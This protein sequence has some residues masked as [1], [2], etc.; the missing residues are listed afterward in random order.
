[1]IIYKLYKE[2]LSISAH[3]QRVDDKKI[4]FYSYDQQ[5]AK[6]TVQIKSPG[7]GKTLEAVQDV[8]IALERG[9]KK[10]VHN[11]TVE[12][13]D[14]NLVSFV[15]PDNIISQSGSFL[16]G[17]YLDYGNNKSLDVGYF[18]INL[19]QSLIDK[20]LPAMEQF[21]VQSFEELKDDI[22]QRSSDLKAIIDGIDTDVADKL[23]TLDDLAEDYAQKAA[24]LEATYAP[25]L[26]EVTAELAQT[27]QQKVG[28]GVKASLEDLDANVLGAIE[29]GEGTSFNLLS[30]PQDN[31]VTTQK[32]ED[33]LRNDL[34]KPIQNKILNGNFLNGLTNW[35]APSGLNANVTGGVVTLTKTDTGTE[36]NFSQ[37][38]NLKQGNL[39]YLKADVRSN[40]PSMQINVGG[41]GPVSHT[42]SGNFEKLS[43]VFT[44]SINGN[45]TARVRFFSFAPADTV[46]DVTKY[47]L[48]DLTTAFGAGN[49]PDK[50]FMDDFID[51]YYAGYFEDSGNVA[52][53][54]F[55]F[56]EVSTSKKEIETIKTEQNDL[57]TRVQTVEEEND[58]AVSTTI[59]YTNKILTEEEALST[60]ITRHV[61]SKP[62][63]QYLYIGGDE[64]V[65]VTGGDALL[66][67]NLAK[68][69]DVGLKVTLTGNT[70]A[71]I[72]KDIAGDITHFQSLCA[73]IYIEDI[74]KV[75]PVFL[76]IM[77]ENLVEMAY[78]TT[79]AERDGNF[80]K[81][82]WNLMRFRTTDGSSFTTDYGSVR[83]LRITAAGNES[84]TNTTFI[85][86]GS[87]WVEKNEKAKFMFIHDGG[88]AHF[89]DENERGY[90]DLKNRG[91]PVINA[92][93]P[94]R[95]EDN[96][97]QPKFMSRTRLY[98]TSLENN[99]EISIHSYAAEDAIATMTPDELK[100][101]SFKAIDLLKSWGYNPLWRAAWYRNNAP[102]A[103]GSKGLFYAFAMSGAYSRV[104]KIEAFPF[105]NMYNVRRLQ[106]HS[107]TNELT[108]TRF[109]ELQWTRGVFVG[110]THEVKDNET[111][112]ISVADWD[113]LLSKLDAAMAEGWL[114]CVTF[115][116]LMQPYIGDG[117][118]STYSKLPYVYR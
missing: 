89:F 104:E 95:I 6:I 55:L 26:T 87:V 16:C 112:D 13:Y 75:G 54:I 23:Q 66:D 102:S 14:E 83:R 29:G 28:G 61:S 69:G 15:L 77:D 27:K 21:Y 80:V 25:R 36:Y 56:D 5:T 10:A 114:E 91:I 9:G 99:N 48:I 39:Y 52:N 101:E 93:C 31:S 38:T 113:Y 35:S 42:G 40:T 96:I 51:K 106:L 88:Y 116:D 74:S 108:D 17:I 105:P 68:G 30:I 67:A 22:I 8:L 109:A 32:L 71:V 47:I 115:K 43:R 11:M 41:I 34:V 64:G 72:A 85:A 37:A 53:N 90:I 18:R 86:V 100:E 24:D 84:N 46:I 3:R 58:N 117:V 59:D 19:K 94:F 79:M 2:T 70:V 78:S 82:G 20:D 44:S 45:T 50:Q 49:E 110:Y 60:G 107:V 81:N 65:T 118:E 62:T 63:N 73:W 7:D 33:T 76:R 98:E 92:T 103:M 1:M 12:D 4:D 97:N 111:G 57:S